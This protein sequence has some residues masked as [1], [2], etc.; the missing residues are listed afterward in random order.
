MIFILFEVIEMKILKEMTESD[1]FALMFDET[2]DCSVT[3]QLAIHGR[4]ICKNSGELKT[5]FLKVIDVLQPEIDGSSSNDTTCVSVCASVITARV[6]EFID[7]AQIDVS[8]L[9]GIGTDGAA[10]MIGCHSGV[11]TRLKEIAPSAVGVH[12]AA[13]RLNLASTHA[14]NAIPYVKKFNQIIHQLFD[15]FDNSVVCTGSLLAIQ[16]INPGKG[17]NFGSMFHKMA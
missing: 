12:C 7:K 1:H 10:T 3:E 2:T 16:K 13:H 6:Q 15:Y 5:C 17:Q 14:A 9:R 8:K 11:V 4:Y